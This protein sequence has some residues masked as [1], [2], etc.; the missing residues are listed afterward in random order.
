MPFPA[1]L[2]WSSTTRPKDRLERRSWTFSPKF[3]MRIRN[4]HYRVEFIKSDRQAI[5]DNQF[6]TAADFENKILENIIQEKDTT[7]IFDHEY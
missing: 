5:I 3:S 6:K 1:P 4:R 7:P 2:F